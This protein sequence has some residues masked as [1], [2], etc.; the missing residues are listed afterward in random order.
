MVNNTPSGAKKHRESSKPES[1]QTA[2]ISWEALWVW[3]EASEV[4]HQM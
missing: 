1:R 2:K 3:A 4:H